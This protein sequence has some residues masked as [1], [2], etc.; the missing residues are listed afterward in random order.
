MIRVES[1]LIQVEFIGFSLLEIYSYFILIWADLLNLN[2]ELW[3]GHFPPIVD[4]PIVYLQK[5]THTGHDKNNL[6]SEAL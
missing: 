2:T 4:T 3:H 5:A 6:L 1:E